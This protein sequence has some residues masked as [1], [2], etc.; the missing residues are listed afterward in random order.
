MPNLW[1]VVAVA[2]VWDGVLW[3]VVG[4]LI[5]SVL[6]GGWRTVLVVAILAFLPFLVLLRGLGG[7]AY[8]SAFV[9]IWVL[10][11]FWYAQ[12]ALLLLALSGLAGMLAGLPFGAAGKLGRW[13]I[14]VV[15]VFLILG[16]VWGYMGTK[17]LVVRPLD[18]HFPELAPALDGIRIVQLSDLH[19]GPNTSV[20]HLS[21]IAEA[22]RNAEP[23]LIVLTGDQVD[24]FARDVEPLG[25]A[26][27][28]LTAPLG[29]IAVAGNHDVYAGWSAVRKGMERIGWTVLVNE[30]IPIEVNGARFWVAG[31]GDP[32]GRGGPGG[33]DP[34]VIPDVERTLA[35]VP[36]G[37]FVLALAH[38][39]SL[40][41]ELAARGVELTLSGHTH[42]GQ[43]AIPRLGWSVASLFLEHAM[44]TYR[45]GNSVLYI[46]P[47]TNY[48]GIPLRIG[49]PPE[50]TVVKLHRDPAGAAVDGASKVKEGVAVTNSSK[51]P[52]G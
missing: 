47:G 1:K 37:E 21:R 12:L 48:W 44:G 43:I 13:A 32:A 16:A 39:P 15:G 10:R 28:G 6:P 33:A 36:D 35:G 11:P 50:V 41:P 19:V 20:R 2:L 14:A 3:L 4:G 17:R 38:N 8:P 24:D 40:W 34:S 30:S 23:D 9:R 27:G 51:Q 52:D 5:A 25:R 29:V 46:N 31:T 45:N 7:D 49:T 42:Y 22:V 26:F 18:L